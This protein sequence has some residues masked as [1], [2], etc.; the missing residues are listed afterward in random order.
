MLK[1]ALL[2]L[3][4][5]A[6][7][8]WL[9]YVAF[10]ILNS[11]DEF[12]P[13]ALFNK[14]DEAILIVNR[15]D[16]TIFDQ[17]EGFTNSPFYN[18]ANAVDKNEYHIGFFSFQRNHG[19]FERADG[20][21]KSN[22]RNLLSPVGEIIFSGETFSIGNLKGRFRKT[23]LYV[24]ENE[25]EVIEESL[26]YKYDKKASAAII[27]FNDQNE[28]LSNTD[29]YF[30]GGGRVN[31]ITKHVKE[32]N[33][34]K[35][36]DEKVFSGMISSGFSSYHFKERIFWSTQDSIFAKSPLFTWCLNGF[37]ELDYKGEKVIV[38]DYMVGQD[39]ILV[40]ND[41]T[42]IYDT[43]RFNIP[44]TNRFPEVG[45]SYWV[46]YLEDLVVIAHSKETCDQLIADYKLGNTIAL[47]P[48]VKDRLYG[49]LPKA[50]SERNVTK[51]LIYSRT[52]YND[53]ILESYSD[54]NIKVNTSNIV[55][56]DNLSMGLES[57]ITDFCLMSPNASSYA[58]LSK[59]G[60]IALFE[61]GKQKWNSTIEGRTM[62][63]IQSIDL[64]ADGN[65]YCLL[66]TKDK[67]YL[68]S[69]KGASS[70]GFPLLLEED[71]I[72]TVKF[73]RWKGKS[74]FLVA[75]AGG[76]VYQYDGKGR[77]INIFKTGF[78]ITEPINVWA[79]QGKLFGGFSNGSRFMM[80]EIERDREYRSF[81]LL[82]KSL[83]LKVPN[84]L[85]HF[86]LSEGTFCRQD[87]KGNITRY[88][89][90]N[91]P[92]LL[93]IIK[94]KSP[95]IVLQSANTIHILNQNGMPFS[96]IRLPFNEV[97][98]IDIHTT[99]SGKTLIAVLDGLENNV[100]LYHSDGNLFKSKQIE[101]EKKV[102][103]R[104]SGQDLMITTIVDKYLIQYYEN[105]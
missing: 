50:V 104:S 3:F 23:K 42:Q 27:R 70:T 55:Q 2:A 85:L 105:N 38:S 86:G 87:Q 41:L 16:E 66:N 74:Y 19:L 30:K 89:S 21:N 46:D 61:N 68:Y 43:T 49:R 81:D 97:Q 6:S 88:Q 102:E 91:S 17:I 24:F 39:P 9:A 82:G 76:K 72:G 67:I 56:K 26:E 75:T 7:A 79:S 45:K 48:G 92:K 15:P 12:N 5:L 100:Y 77:E 93:K 25:F 101:G 95:Y 69:E 40:L 4:I 44:L 64:Y 33:G 103:L 84:E 10:D 18:I 98:N 20:W 73:Y 59:D 28:L 90:Y 60:Q 63:D 52:Y 62:G 47:S 65:S 94:D 31:Y 83:A 53:R 99:D 1:R 54:L 71:A 96:E 29:I 37:I 8:S 78:D 22:I 35:V 32:L 14:N 80:Y 57:S 11:E 13:L 51:D 34:Q 36:D 58:A